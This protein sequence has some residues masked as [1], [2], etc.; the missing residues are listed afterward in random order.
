MPDVGVRDFPRPQ[1]DKVLRNLQYMMNTRF[2]AMK[3]NETKEKLNLE[4]ALRQIRSPFP[5]ARIRGVQEIK[6]LVTQ[7]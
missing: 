7:V 2:E 5:A 6:G 1:A 3:I 4:I